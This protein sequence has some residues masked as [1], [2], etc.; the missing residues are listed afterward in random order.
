MRVHT[1]RG[2]G[3]GRCSLT[4]EGVRPGAGFESIP[5]RAWSWR[6]ETGSGVTTPALPPG[7]PTAAKA[8]FG[9]QL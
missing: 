3:G 7:W 5:A 8:C 4:G 1:E 9:W 6:G 2:R